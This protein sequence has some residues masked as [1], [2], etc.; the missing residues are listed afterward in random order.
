[1]HNLAPLVSGRARCT[2]MMHPSDAEARGVEEGERVEVRS[3][4][5]V[6][7]V[8]VERSDALMP[9]VVCLPHG[10]G[11]G[12][13]GAELSVASSHAGV[14][15]NVLTDDGV[16]DPAS[17]NAVLNGIPVEVSALR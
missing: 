9:G 5:G 11:H 4:V 1:M 10:W 2:L 13:E 7:E 14:G 6:L 15:S 12:V 17:G 8:E 3:R 16:I